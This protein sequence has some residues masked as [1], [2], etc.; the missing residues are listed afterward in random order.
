MSLHVLALGSLVADPVRRTGAKGNFATATLRVATEDGAILV[1]AIAF[2]AAAES[3]LV[4]RQGGAVAV[5]GRARLSKWTSRDGQERHGLAIVAEQ[6]ASAG[7]ARRADLEQR[8]KRA[9]A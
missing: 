9:A 6:V 5:S 3:L 2:A 1:S 8:R 4:L 7:A